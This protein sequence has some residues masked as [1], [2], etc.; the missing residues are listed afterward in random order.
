MQ[1]L[2]IWQEMYHSF[3]NN[4]CQQ[5]IIEVHDKKKSAQWRGWPWCYHRPTK[6]NNHG[7]L[8]RHFLFFTG[9]TYFGFIWWIFLKLE[10]SAAFATWSKQI[11]LHKATIRANL[12]FRHRCWGN[13][14]TPVR[15]LKLWPE[16]WRLCPCMRRP[17]HWRNYDLW[18][19][20]KYVSRFCRTG[21]TCIVWVIIPWGV[22]NISFAGHCL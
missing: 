11:S 15:F 6:Q 13:T 22:N 2:A 10:L 18:W 3:S 16:G 7:G 12:C 21:S 17:K 1:F 5:D 20:G 9:G 4:I 19:T 8:W 14:L